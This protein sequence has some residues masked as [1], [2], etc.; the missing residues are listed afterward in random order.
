M[1]DTFHHIIHTGSP[2]QGFRH[3]DPGFYQVL[4]RVCE[5]RQT[6]TWFDILGTNMVCNEPMT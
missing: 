2:Y 4:A 5:Q 6:Q 1:L 3:T